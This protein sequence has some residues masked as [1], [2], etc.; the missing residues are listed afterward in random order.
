[1]FCRVAPMFWRG[2]AQVLWGGAQVPS[3]GAQVLSGGAQVLSGG[4]HRNHITHA[5]HPRA[6]HVPNS[7]HI[8]FLPN[9]SG[10]DNKT[11]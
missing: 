8:G 5:V 3:G 2:G 1:M 4:A 6:R 11:S 7:I 9:V 10:R